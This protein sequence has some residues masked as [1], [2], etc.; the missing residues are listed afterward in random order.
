[1]EDQRLSENIIK[2]VKIILE[3]TSKSD[4]QGIFL[5]QEL[6]YF[7]NDYIEF[8]DETDFQDTLKVFTAIAKDGYDIHGFALCEKPHPSIYTFYDNA[9][10]QI[11]DICINHF[12]NCKFETYVAYMDDNHNE[13]YASSIKEA[14]SKL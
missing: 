6:E 2:S 5:Q 13:C 4:F 1:M 11:F 14:V 8:G 12:G 3:N 7:L 9:T 10:G